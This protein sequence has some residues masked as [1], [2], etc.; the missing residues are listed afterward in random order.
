LPAIPNA[1]ILAYHGYV[2]DP[3]DFFPGY[4][5]K[6]YLGLSAYPKGVVDRVSGV[7]SRSAWYSNMMNR[8]SVPATVAINLVTRN[9]DTNTRVFTGTFEFKAL[10]NLTG[11]YR[12]NIYLVED[13]IVWPQ[14]GSLGGPNYV[15]DWTVRAIMNGAVGD[16]IVNGTWN[17][18]QVITKSIT[19]TYPVP[20]S[21]APDIVP[22]SCYIAVVVYKG[23]QPSSTSS[24]IQQADQWTLISPDYVAV[25]LPRTPD[26]IAPSSAPVQFEAVL[27]NEGLMADRYYFNLSYTGPA[28]WV[29]QYTTANGTFALGQVDSLDINS[30][31]STTVTVTVDP[32]STDGY[33]VATLEFT[34]KNNPA[35]SGQVDFRFVTTTGIDILVVDAED[36]DYE[37]FIT[38]S[39]DHVFSGTYGVV[40]R[41]ALRPAGVDLSNFKVMTWSQGKTFP[42][43]VPEEV[44]ALQTY[45]DGGGMLFINGQDIG[46]DIFEPNGQSS[47]AQSFYNNY[48]HADYVSNSSTWFLMNGYAGDPITDGIQF[49]LGGPYTKSPEIIAPF[50]ANATPILKYYNGP[51][52]GAIRAATNTYR[53]VYLG[54]GFEQIDQEAIRDTIM[55]R[56]LAWLYE[57]ISAIGDNPILAQKFL[58]MQNYPNPFNPETTIRYL[59]DNP[60]AK[61]TELTIYNSLGQKVRTLVSAKQPAGSYEVIWNGRDDNGREVASGIYYY[62][63]KSGNKLFTQKMILMR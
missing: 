41:T 34:S 23:S 4:N 39:L 49:V 45:L 26:A 6:S 52:V 53:V 20:P 38:N 36:K 25:M 2:N 54:I 14:A 27:R 9:Y 55:A 40:S 11:E 22:D 50:D 58:L 15:H 31:D 62:R 43:F 42:A 47:F 7:L 29:P 59:L 24:E 16:Q 32:N 28:N 17:Q 61:Q 57:G 46:A 5:I 35:L 13:G 37:T 1:V 10:Q 12:Y 30:G 18:N 63:L 19:Y 3:F 33:G 51:T 60:T 44:T 48:L 21:P 8:L 56:S